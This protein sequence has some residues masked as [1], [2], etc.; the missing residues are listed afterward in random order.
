VSAEVL[1]FL[2]LT[3]AR[4]MDDFGFLSVKRDQLALMFGGKS[5][6][7]IQRWYGQAVAAGL[8][9]S[10]SRGKPG[11]AAVYRGLAQPPEC[12]TGSGVDVSHIAAAGSTVECGTRSGVDVS[13][14]DE[15]DNPE[16]GTDSGVDVSRINGSFRMGPILSTT[17][18][19]GPNVGHDHAQAGPPV[20]KRA[21][22]P[23]SSYVGSGEAQAE[24]F[25]GQQ[26]QTPAA[27]LV[28]LE[29]SGASNVHNGKA[30]Q[31]AESATTPIAA[32]VTEPRREVSGTVEPSVTQLTTGGR[33]RSRQC[34]HPDCGKFLTR[35]DADEL[36]PEHWQLMDRRRRAAQ[37]AATE[38]PEPSE[39]AE[40]LTACPALFRGQDGAVYVCGVRLDGKRAQKAGLC[41]Q[42]R[43]EGYD[44][45]LRPTA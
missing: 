1:F 33:R 4:Y 43:L 45:E 14:I 42:H 23:H 18:D 13:H 22:G 11:A 6:K 40:P 36:C 39:E 30:Q 37:R 19:F 26:Q 32:P 27:G 2:A 38:A 15:P 44:L 5:E 12:G 9:E 31:Q 16:C 25:D 35:W 17:P 7:T 8:L 21:E 24:F 10:V 41:E 20:V 29:E 28:D 3:A 34:T